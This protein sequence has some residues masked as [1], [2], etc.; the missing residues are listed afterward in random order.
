MS[1]SGVQGNFYLGTVASVPKDGNFEIVADIPGVIRGVKAFPL[2][3]DCD[4]PK[5]GDAIILLGLDPEYN[6]YY[7]YW[8]LKEND[9][10]GFRAYG[11]EISIEED[12]LVIRSYS[13]ENSEDGE[14]E[15]GGESGEKSSIR[16]DKNGNIS[17]NITG[18]AKIVVENEA[19]IEATTATVK[20][21]DVEIGAGNTGVGT[22]KINSKGVIPS[23]NGGPFV[24]FPGQLI[25]PAPGVPIPTGDTIILG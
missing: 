16:L 10:T 15:P 24:A 18:D 13:G 4:E 23:A 8:K 25:T 1:K 14:H 17:I 19:K 9:F 12:A 7:L 3:G 11:K 2:R 21:V 6:S 22:L 20:A 5:P